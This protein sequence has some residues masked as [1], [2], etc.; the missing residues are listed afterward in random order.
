MPD[1]VI[2]VVNKIGKDEGIP[3]RIH[4][5][6]IHKVL[7]LDDWYG[8]VESQDGSTCASDESWGMPKDGGEID[9]KNT[10]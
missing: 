2:E 6:N 4:F 9:Q 8:D 10:I 5:C 1:N 3:D 7:N